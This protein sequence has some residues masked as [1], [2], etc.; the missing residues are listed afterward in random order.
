METTEK[1]IIDEKKEGRFM[2]L[3]NYKPVPVRPAF[4]VQINSKAFLDGETESYSLI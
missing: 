3:E 2:D 1:K 4:T